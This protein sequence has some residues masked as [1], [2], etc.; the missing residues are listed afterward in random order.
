MSPTADSK[1]HS[2][3]HLLSCDIT[4]HMA[5]LLVTHSRSLQVLR[6]TR[7][8]ETALLGSQTATP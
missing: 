7:D 4:H 3:I 8:Q 2:S 1:Y 5:E 6:Q